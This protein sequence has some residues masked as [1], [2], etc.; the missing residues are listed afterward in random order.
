M[1]SLLPSFRLAQFVALLLAFALCRRKS[2]AALGVDRCP[3]VDAGLG[4]IHAVLLELFASFVTQTFNRPIKEAEP[5]RSILAS[6]FNFLVFSPKHRRPLGEGRV[7]GIVPST[8][9]P[10]LLQPGSPLFAS[11]DTALYSTERFLLPFWKR[12]CQFELFVDDGMVSSFRIGLSPHFPVPHPLCLLLKGH[13]GSGH[14]QGAVRAVGGRDSVISALSLAKAARLGF[15]AERRRRNCPGLPPA[16]Q[17]LLLVQLT[18]LFQGLGA[19]L[20]LAAAFYAL[21]ALRLH[22]LRKW[23]RVALGL[24]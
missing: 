11:R 3:G 17:R 15:T 12:A 10:G 24:M 23:I 8:S 19:A 6:P 22:R 13:N 21:E 14:C 4:F 5:I 1:D 16:A 9:V 7:A 2:G 20:G 18:P